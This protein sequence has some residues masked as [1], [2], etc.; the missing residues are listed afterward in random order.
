MTCRRL[1]LGLDAVVIGE[2][3]D[4]I[5]LESRARLMPGRWID[6]LLDA[7]HTQRRAFVWTWRVA[8]LGSD[9]VTYRGSCRWQVR[10]GKSLPDWIEHHGR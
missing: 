8:S 9:G 2:D 1:R 10:Q 6:L 7:G 5:E 4:G 3:R